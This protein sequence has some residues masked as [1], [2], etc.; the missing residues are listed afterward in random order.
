MDVG[1]GKGQAHWA[2]PV[3]T[4]GSGPLTWLPLRSA[5][6]DSSTQNFF[7]SPSGCIIS[8][9]MVVARQG[10]GPPLILI[11]SKAPERQVQEAG[12]LLERGSAR[13]LWAEQE[14]QNGVRS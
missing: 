14:G 13:F 3:S 1:M 2:S 10:G 7:L 9:S 8:L 6:L 4:V 5:S 12:D 11:A